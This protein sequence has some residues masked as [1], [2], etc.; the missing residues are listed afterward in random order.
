MDLNLLLSI[1]IGESLIRERHTVRLNVPLRLNWIVTY[2][3]NPSLTH[4]QAHGR[5]K[6]NARVQFIKTHCIIY[7]I[8]IYFFFLVHKPTTKLTTLWTFTYG[9]SSIKYMKT[10]SQ[11]YYGAFDCSL[12]LN[13]WKQILENIYF[14]LLSLEEKNVDTIQNEMQ[15]IQ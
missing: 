4:S 5:I 14:L 15:K 8:F 10:K 2:K 7:L 1:I 3:L 13:K 11:F 6:M 12:F 9:D